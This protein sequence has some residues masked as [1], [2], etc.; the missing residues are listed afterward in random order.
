MLIFRCLVW[1]TLVFLLSA[2]S[3]SRPLTENRSRNQP[4]QALRQYLNE[5]AKKNQFE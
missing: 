2:G 1:I 4:I 3:E 5:E